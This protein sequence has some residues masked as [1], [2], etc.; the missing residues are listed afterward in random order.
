MSALKYCPPETLERL[1]RQHQRDGLPRLVIRDT[2][3]SQMDPE[4]FDII[5]N[6]RYRARQKCD[7]FD[8]AQFEIVAAIGRPV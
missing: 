5:T 4:G 8:P 3:F 6:E 1:G 2:T 7:G